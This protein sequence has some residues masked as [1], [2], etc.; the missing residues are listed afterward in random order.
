MCP[1]DGRTRKLGKHLHHRRKGLAAQV[2]RGGLGDRVGE[3]EDREL[4]LNDPDRPARADGHGRGASAPGDSE[5]RVAPQERERQHRDR[6]HLTPGLSS[7]ERHQRK[8]QAGQ[9][10]SGEPRPHAQ[11]EERG[12]RHDDRPVGRG[13]D[14]GAVE[15]PQ[16]RAGLDDLGERPR[17]RTERDDDHGREGDPEDGGGGRVDGG[18]QGAGNPVVPVGRFS[19]RHQPVRK[20]GTPP[21]DRAACCSRNSGWST[22]SAFRP[23]RSPWRAR[24]A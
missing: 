12:D 22:R 16:G 20:T 19:A 24:R 8:Q 6:E 10:G 15:A 18:E 1:S 23:A 5:C 13:H 7:L 4:E 17:N 9:R 11:G 14:D 21:F 3:V 2:V